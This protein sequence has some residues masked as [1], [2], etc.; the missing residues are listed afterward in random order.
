MEASN[1]PA[2]RDVNISCTAEMRSRC[3]DICLDAIAMTH[4]HRHGLSRC[5][6]SAVCGKQMKGK[7][8][9]LH[10]LNAVR[11]PWASS[12]VIISGYD[13][14]DCKSANEMSRMLILKRTVYECKRDML[15]LAGDAMLCP[16]TWRWATN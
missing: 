9:K 4:S 10:C 7:N 5:S 13:R 2:I 3:F 6:S 12:G 14:T 16:G 8:F 15:L 1:L 11:F